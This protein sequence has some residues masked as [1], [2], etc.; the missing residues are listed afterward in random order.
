MYRH[1]STAS[2]LGKLLRRVV[3]Q[4]REC[5]AQPAKSRE[6]RELQQTVTGRLLALSGKIV[7][8]TKGNLE[9]SDS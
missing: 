6:R 2:F 1:C 5:A 7:K 3:V 8:A 9:L 4:Q